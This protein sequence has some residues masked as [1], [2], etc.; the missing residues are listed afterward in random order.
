MGRARSA[1]S[2]FSSVSVSWICGSEFWP[3]EIT[4]D[5][6]IISSIF[7]FRLLCRWMEKST[8]FT[9]KIHPDEI[10]LYRN[11]RTED[12][13]PGNVMWPMVLTIPTG[14][15]IL[16]FFYSRDRTELWHSLMGWTLALGLN[17]IFTDVLKLLVGEWP[18]NFMYLIHSVNGHC[19]S[20]EKFQKT[21]NM[22][23]LKCKNSCEIGVICDTRLLW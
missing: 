23:C 4:T 1:S 5:Q 13:V 6:L 15:F 17:G 9:R 22:L 12:Y 8:P 18:N 21:S 7:I 19:L 11:P 14:I 3:T 20:M 10:W 2:F 16:Y